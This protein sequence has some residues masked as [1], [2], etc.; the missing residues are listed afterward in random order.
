MAKRRRVTFMKYIKSTI[1][2]FLLAFLP[3]FAQENRMEISQDIT[4]QKNVQVLLKKEVSEALLETTG[5][6]YIYNPYDGTKVVSGILGKRFIVHGIENGLKWGQFFSGIHQ[7]YIVPRSEKTSILVDGIEYEG[8]IAVYLTE[9]K[10]SIVND[11]D[12]E[13]FIK[14]TL[15]P[16][17]PYPLEKETM[18]A[19]AIL[20]RTNVYFHVAKSKD[21]F[22]HLDAKACGYLGK[23]MVSEGSAID[24]AVDNTHDLILTNDN[25]PFAA[26]WTDHC[27]GKTA[28]Y[29]TIFRKTG[30]CPNV[31]VTSPHAAFD[32][33]KSA[34]N[35]QISKERI[36]YLFDMK[37]L[38]TIDL[39]TD[40]ES[41]KIYGVQLNGEKDKK[42]IDFFTFQEK[43]GK[44]FV[45]IKEEG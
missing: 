20:E 30:H 23:A 2:L 37:D 3:S 1:A 22:W 18:A 14:S 6:Y 43:I 25:D 8:A 42:Q 39:F 28:P 17:F 19:I 40:K 33:E 21:K 10:I 13:S 5:P 34:W 16:K 29:E 27:A 9:D 7:I 36:A 15:T 38:A 45:R 32:R 24:L 26:T 44:N 41:G 4:S 31:V 35:L 11:L 12:V